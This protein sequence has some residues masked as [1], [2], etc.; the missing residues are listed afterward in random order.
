M[1]EV[2]RRKFIQLSVIGGAVAA[3]GCHPKS[4][5]D[6]RIVAAEWRG[7]YGGYDDRPLPYVNQ[8]DGFVDGVPQYFAT[9]CQMCPAGCGLFIRTMGGRAHNAQGNPIHPVSGGKICSRGVASLQHLYEP[10]R[11][12]FPTARSARGTASAT[13]DWETALA[14]MVSGLQTG[15]GKIAVLT[16]AMTFGRMPTMSRLISEFAEKTGAVAYSYSLL[17]DA[18]WRAA[19]R[20][21]YGK[22]QVPAYQIDQADCILAFSSNFLEAWPSPVYYSRLFGE[23]RQGPRRKQGEHGRFVYIGPRMSMTAANADQW[24]PCNPGTEELLARAIGTAISGSESSLADAANASGISVE[25]LRKVAKD[26]SAAGTRA[27]ALGGDVLLSHPNGAAAMIAV[28]SL[29][30]QAKSQCVG[31]GDAALPLAPAAQ[32]G[33]QQIQRLV[34][35]INAGQVGALLILGQSNPVFTLPSATGFADALAKV[36]F[37]AALTPYEDETTAYADVH[38]PTRTF[39]EDWG[40]DVP[41]VIPPGAKMATLRQP[42]INPQFVTDSP[43]LSPADYAPDMAPWMDTRPSG[44]ILIDLGKRLGKISPYVDT[45]DAVRHTWSTLKQADLKAPGTHNDPAWVAALGKGGYWTESAAPPAVGH[46]PAMGAAANTAQPTGNMFALHLFP[47]IYWTDGRGANL[48]WMQEGADPMTSSVWNSWVEINLDTAMRLEIRTG[49]ILR[50]TTAHGHL[51]APAVPSPG[52]HPQAVA[53]PIGQGHTLYGRGMMRQGGNPL[54][55]LEPIAEAQTGALAFNGTIVQVEKLRSAKDG[56]H[57][58]LDTLVLTQDR[59]GGHEPAAVQNLIHTTANE[60]KKAKPVGGVPKSP[61]SIFNRM[62]GRPP[63][64][65]EK[66]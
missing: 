25:D 18:P 49:D 17:D 21:V 64:T 20:A 53:M 40:D 54:R 15:A 45:R 61:E 16:D 50:L 8:P 31:F 37:I 66:K 6:D 63:T 59:T 46:A 3:T 65:T 33:Y 9:V 28:E 11:L 57:P 35:Q 10:G 52:I 26:F 5:Y 2:S 19:A 56:Y 41:L 29:N 38:L 48:G 55:I 36:P 22:D 42:V 60:W 1:T 34:S 4:K 14:R 62:S 51:D 43:G 32:S 7:Q 30:A 23:F 24:L 44:D 12:R 58:E 39:L 47:H 27:V 13:V